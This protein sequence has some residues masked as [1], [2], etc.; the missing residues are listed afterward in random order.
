MF[1][2][3]AVLAR[4]PETE[5]ALR[6][7]GAG[8]RPMSGK[9]SPALGAVPLGLDMAAALLKYPFAS[10]PQQVMVNMMIA[11]HVHNGPVVA[12]AGCA[13]KPI[14]GFVDQ[15]RG[16]H[17]GLSTTGAR[18]TVAACMP[19]VRVHIVVPEATHTAL[20]RPDIVAAA[21]GATME[22]AAVGRTVIAALCAGDTHPKGRQGRGGG[23]G[24]GVREADLFA[25]LSVAPST[26][27]GGAVG[28]VLLAPSALS[29]SALSPTLSDS[30]HVRPWALP[31]PTVSQYVYPSPHAYVQ[32]GH[33]FAQ[34]PSVFSAGIRP[35]VAISMGMGAVGMGMGMGV[36][37]GMTMAFTGAMTPHA[38]SHI[39]M[40]AV[41]SA[42][43][44]VP[45]PMPVPVPAPASASAPSATPSPFPSVHV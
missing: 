38:T 1:D 17:Q 20:D 7:R 23:G 13:A 35:G 15:F 32:D 26:G 34:V 12:L 29:P 41:V 9:G 10:S 36:D 43:V 25:A 40:P 18:F 5:A 42:P 14:A 21:R 33:S 3:M 24:S 27:S 4:D 8:G 44:A 31:F 39:P 28:P 6:R 11:S 19:S 45:M 30:L 2:D 37:M 16:M 22:G